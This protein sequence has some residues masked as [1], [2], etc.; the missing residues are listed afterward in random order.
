MFQQRS[1]WYHDNVPLPIGSPPAGRVSVPAADA[2][3]EPPTSDL[4]PWGCEPERD[5][6]ITEASR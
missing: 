1:D 4:T 2:A 3:G 6:S 5:R